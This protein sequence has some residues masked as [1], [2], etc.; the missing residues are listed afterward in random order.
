MNR[1]DRQDHNAARAATKNLHADPGS[2]AP[3]DVKI[4][5]HP[6]ESASHEKSSQKSQEVTNLIY[7]GR[8]G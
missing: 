5:V 8:N 7:E 3:W 1:E 6:R 2:A 4:R